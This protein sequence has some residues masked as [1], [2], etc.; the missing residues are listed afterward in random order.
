VE[1]GTDP[2]GT[3][4]P[5]DRHDICDVQVDSVAR[6]DAVRIIGSW[7][8]IEDDAG[9]VIGCQDTRSDKDG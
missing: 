4:Q 1:G 6:A 5:E 3:Y 7:Q 9:E 8:P 2:D